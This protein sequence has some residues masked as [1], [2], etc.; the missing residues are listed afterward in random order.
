MDTE[1]QVLDIQLYKNAA[2]FGAMLA[3]MSIDLTSQGDYSTCGAC[4]VFHP[5]YLD[6]GVEI[7]AQPDYIATSGTLNI[8]AIPSASGMKLTAMLS[9]VT[10]EHIMIAPSTFATTKLPDGCKTTLTSAMIDT[11]LP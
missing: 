10:F 1:P 4:V 2:P 9:N 5:R 6:G 3:S 8:T 11:A 7:R